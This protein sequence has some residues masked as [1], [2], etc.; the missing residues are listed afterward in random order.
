MDMIKI[1][2]DGA[3][4]NTRVVMPDGTMIPGIT[5]AMWECGVGEVARAK[6]DAFCKCELSVGADVK[7]KHEAKRVPLHWRRPEDRP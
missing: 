3:G 2:S 7:V 5:K 1:I 6:I 4:N